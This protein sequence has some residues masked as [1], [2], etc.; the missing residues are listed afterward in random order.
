M[1]LGNSRDRIL[2]LIPARPGW[3]AVFKYSACEG[4]TYREPVEAW[5]LTPHG[6]AV[7]LVP[8]TDSGVLVDAT[9]GESF[10][11]LE[12]LDGL[13]GRRQDLMHHSPAPLVSYR[14]LRRK[15]RRVLG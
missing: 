14:A 12:R 11:R 13:D 1:E 2:Q 9:Q 4:D 5:G 8:D 15:G 6:D 10:L 7:P 3:V